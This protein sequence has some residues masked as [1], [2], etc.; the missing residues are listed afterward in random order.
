MKNLK[1]LYVEDDE[2]TRMVLLRQ[3]SDVYS[4]VYDAN[5]GSVGLEKYREH[6]PDV[7]ITDLTMPVMSG[8]EMIKHIQHE[9][10]DQQIIVL[11]GFYDE[12]KVLEG[13]KVL[14]KP[15]IVNEIFRIIADMNS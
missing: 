15:I 2:I 13:C 5:N 11:T 12:S 6:E 9:T 8:I 7:V 4:E 1:I 14:Q 3:L 10:P